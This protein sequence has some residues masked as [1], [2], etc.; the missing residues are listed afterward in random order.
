MFGIGDTEFIL[1]LIFAFLLF[2]PE[3]LP[4]LGKTLG[5]GLR[6]FRD[7]SD[8]VTKVVKTEVL[9]PVQ[10]EMKK[11]STVP[12][13]L[14]QQSSETF[15]QKKARMEQAYKATEEPPSAK[16]PSSAKESSRAESTLGAEN[17]P[18]A[19]RIPDTAKISGAQESTNTK[20]SKA[21]QATTSA[22]HDER[23]QQ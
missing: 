16:E 3:K 12:E 7:A 5:K 18:S 6:Q 9:N 15:A 13:A 21:A 14:P 8:S 17:T 19:E 11:A 20:E 22:A 2:G 4:G 1:I 10:D 23:Q